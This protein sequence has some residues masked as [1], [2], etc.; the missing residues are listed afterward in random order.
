MVV[1]TLVAIGVYELLDAMAGYGIATGEGFVKRGKGESKEDHDARLKEFADVA[2]P[3][4]GPIS[5]MTRKLKHGKW[6]GPKMDVETAEPAE[7]GKKTAK[8][9]TIGTILGRLTDLSLYGHSKA[10]P[11]VWA[12]D[13]EQIHP[14]EE[15]KRKA[16]TDLALIKAGKTPGSYMGALRQEQ[17][18]KLLAKHGTGVGMT[19]KDIDVI[20]HGTG[21]EAPD[22]PEDFG[23]NFAPWV[24]ANEKTLKGMKGWEGLLKQYA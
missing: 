6:F 4:I 1:E 8:A 20:M 22:T 12:A 5:A 7:F 16:P 11:I 18:L 14:I 23:P 3:T 19:V 9:A 24:K 2:Y 15:L 21:Y 17:Y 13:E 10:S